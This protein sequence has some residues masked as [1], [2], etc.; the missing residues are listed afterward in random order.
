M[1]DGDDDER[2]RNGDDEERIRDGDDKGEVLFSQVR[3][4]RWPSRRSDDEEDSD[5]SSRLNLVATSPM[6]KSH[7]K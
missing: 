6:Y 4:R 1:H 2:I 3:W 5:E 7:F